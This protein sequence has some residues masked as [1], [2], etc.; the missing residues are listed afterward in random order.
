MIERATVRIHPSAEVSAKAVIGIGSSIWNQAQVRDGARIGAG[1]I[2]GKNVYV[3]TEVV[4]GDNCKIQNNVSLFHGVTVEDGVFIGPHVCFTNDRLPRAVNRDGSIKTDADWEVSPILIRRGAALGA[5]STI[6]PG[7]TIGRWAMVGA[8][9][10]VTRDVHDH[11]L[12]AGNPARRLGSACPCGQPLRDGPDG[13][14][15]RGSCPR[16]SNA[17][18]PEAGA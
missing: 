9:S 11:E 2:I 12:V 8:G 1:C 18:P 14:P 10:V 15:F 3:D 17:F 4:I 5:N 7:V 6:L 13:T 16:C